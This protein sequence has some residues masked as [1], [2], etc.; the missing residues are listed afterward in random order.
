MARPGTVRLMMRAKMAPQ[1]TEEKRY[2]VIQDGI[3]NCLVMVI[4]FWEKGGSAMVLLD[5]RASNQ[6]RLRLG[7]C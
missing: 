1:P 3:D 7:Y 4:S 2:V 6:S 5:P